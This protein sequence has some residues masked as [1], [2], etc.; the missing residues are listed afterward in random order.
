MNENR[1]QA[2]ANLSM[3][4][5]FNMIKTELVETY[6]NYRQLENEYMKRKSEVGKSCT[7][8]EHLK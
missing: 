2:E 8:L 1:R 6:S 4:P 3:E 7:I 5:T